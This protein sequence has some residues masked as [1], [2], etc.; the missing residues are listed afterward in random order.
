LKSIRRDTDFIKLGVRDPADIVF[1]NIA[2][3]SRTTSMD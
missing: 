2:I 1:E 3:A